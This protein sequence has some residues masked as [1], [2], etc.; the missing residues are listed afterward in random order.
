ME[1]VMS[2]G[3][4]WKEACDRRLCKLESRFGNGK[5]E[6]GQLVAIQEAVEYIL[7]GFDL[8]D[9][10]SVN[11]VGPSHVIC[12]F[13]YSNVLLQDEMF[14]EGPPF[15]Q[16]FQTSVQE[17]FERRGLLPDIVSIDYSLVDI[18][19]FFSPSLFRCGP[20]L[21]SQLR[22]TLSIEDQDTVLAFF[23]RLLLSIILLDFT[24]DHLIENAS[25]R[26]DKGQVCKPEFA[27]MMAVRFTFSRTNVTWNLATELRSM[28]K[29]LNLYVKVR[30]FTDAC[31][32]VSLT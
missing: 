19:F 20:H 10:N 24:V 29:L 5:R 4:S 15:T 2:S 8:A 6:L 1:L 30:H 32:H 21:A 23:K 12:F 17:I 11:W 28:I 13:L 9:I 26:G 18:F 7:E 27:K 22:T 25:V 16:Q 14:P 3:M 31:S